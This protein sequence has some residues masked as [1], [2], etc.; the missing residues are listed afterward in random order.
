LSAKED[1]LKFWRPWSLKQLE[2]LQ[3]TNVSNPCCQQFAQSYVIG[4]IQSGKGI[5]HY[6]KTKL[7]LTRGTFYIIAPEEVWSCQ[8]EALTFSHLFV[9]PSLLQRVSTEI[10]GAQKSRLHFPDSRLH[11]ISLSLFF[12]ELFARFTMSASRLEQDDLLLQGVAQLLLWRSE[13]RGADERLERDYSAIKRVKAYLAEH[14]A[15]N[16][17]LEELANI[18]H[19]NTFHLAHLFRHVVGLPPHAYQIQLRLSHA[20]E[21]L[22]QGFP[23]GYVAHE[24][25]FFDQTHFTYHFKRHIGVTPGTYRK[26]ARSY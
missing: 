23:V 21:L 14:Y 11:D 26:T 22:V 13:D 15:E 24:T 1:R 9:D 5:L 7:E 19:L 2:L 17:S 25:G 18:A 3:G 8:A 10:V 6:R 4:T 12:E 16:V 20:R